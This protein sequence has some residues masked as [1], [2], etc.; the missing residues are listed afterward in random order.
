MRFIIALY[1]S[2]HP[3]VTRKGRAQYVAEFRDFKAFK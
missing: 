2:V 3:I 1:Q